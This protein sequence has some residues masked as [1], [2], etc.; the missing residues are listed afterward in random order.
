M[1]EISEASDASVEAIV[2][3][4]AREEQGAKVS[5]P[6]ED[7]DGVILTRPLRDYRVVVS[8]PCY[9]LARVMLRV[10]RASLGANKKSTRHS[11]MTHCEL[12]ACCDSLDSARRE[13]YSSRISGY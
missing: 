1:A 9:E 11:R 13:L 3:K 5:K 12:A 8:L 7:S 4:E 2:A 6:I 10:T